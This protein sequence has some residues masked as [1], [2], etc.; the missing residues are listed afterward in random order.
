MRRRRLAAWLF[1]RGWFRLAWFVSMFDAAPTD[2][3]HLLMD[4]GDEDR[5][6]AFT[7][8]PVRADCATD[9]HYLCGLCSRRAAML[10]ADKAMP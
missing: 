5:C 6:D 8:E 7:A 9:G 10:S 3:A 4:P 1:R 2:R